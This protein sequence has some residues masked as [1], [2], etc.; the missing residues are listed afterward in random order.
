MSQV[1]VSTRVFRLLRIIKD[2]ETGIIRVPA[3]QRD[4][5]WDYNKKVQLFESILK[6]LPIGTIFLWR[7][8]FIDNDNYRLFESNSIG[9]YDLPSRAIDYYYVLDGLQRLSTLF[10]CLIDENQTPLKKNNKLWTQQ[11]FNLIYNLESNQ[12]EK[13][14]KNLQIFEIE[15]HRFIDHDSYADFIDKMQNENISLDRKQLFRNRYVHFQKQITTFDLPI[16]ELTGATIEE[17]V[18]IFD[19]L[20]STGAKVTSEWKLNALSFNIEK[21][22]RLGNEI[23]SLL[24]DLKEY[25]FHKLDRKV[26]FNSIINSF[27]VVFFDKSSE[28]DNRKIE[29]LAND[30]VFIE[31]TRD[32][33]TAIKKAVKFLYYELIVIDSKLLPYNNQL[34]FITDFFSKVKNP[35]E[36][37]LQELKKWFWITTY[38]NYFTIYNLSKQR[39]AYDT[40]Q[41]FIAFDDDPVYVDDSRKKFTTEKFPTKISMGSVRGKALALFMLNYS[42]NF[43]SLDKNDN[44]I[45]F[46]LEKIIIS[47]NNNG[48]TH[49][50]SNTSEN[51]I[52]LHKITNSKDDSFKKNHF[53]EEFNDD[54]EM[55]LEHRK[56]RIMRQEM[57]FVKSLGIEYYEDI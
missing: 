16:V 50:F 2:F 5:E 36:Y 48:N 17:A 39:R 4:F 11:G 24:L 35:T 41:F 12:I 43:K 53:L 55:F 26:I 33:I 19:K 57:N 30:P 46:R 38:S 6:G 42:R 51:T 27:G 54:F 1:S 14:R 49:I 40:F 47:R 37:Q 7:P 21:G 29:I 13:G 44:S 9:G 52:V 8:D 31:N 28:N 45:V 22:F 10:G 34:I 15:L 23:D 25:N 18:E 32:T 56:L 3:F 20:N